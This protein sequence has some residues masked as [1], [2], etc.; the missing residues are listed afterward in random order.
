MYY[1]I[2]VVGISAFLGV[3]LFCLCCNKDDVDI[4]DQTDMTADV[5]IR[6]DD[7]GR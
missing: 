6:F 4:H 3:A 1:V 2:A 7:I 5:S